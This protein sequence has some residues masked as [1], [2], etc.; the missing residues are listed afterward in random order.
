MRSLRG[1]NDLVDYWV[2]EMSRRITGDA[3]L[4]RLHA[5]ERRLHLKL[6]DYAF[7]IA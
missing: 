1:M 5:A 2:T 6:M 3:P 4:Q 7:G